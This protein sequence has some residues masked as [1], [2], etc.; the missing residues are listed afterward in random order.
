MF[1]LILFSIAD[2]VGCCSASYVALL[3]FLLLLETVLGLLM[4]SVVQLPILGLHPVA[5]RT[6][7]ST[8]DPDALSSGAH[9]PLTVLSNPWRSISSAAL[10]FSIFDVRPRQLRRDEL[11]LVCSAAI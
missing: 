3:M 7:R 4:L 10:A 2:D 9:Q 6:L 5:Q 8:P 11:L 1:Y